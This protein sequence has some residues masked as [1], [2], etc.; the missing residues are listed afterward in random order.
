M[1]ASCQFC[2]PMSLMVHKKTS[3]LI[4]HSFINLTKTITD[5]ESA[6]MVLIK[7]VHWS[8]GNTFW[9]TFGEI[10]EGTFRRETKPFTSTTYNLS[11]PKACPEVFWCFRQDRDLLYWP[12]DL[13]IGT[14]CF[15]MF[16]GMCFSSSPIRHWSF[17]R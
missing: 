14:E 8:D 7:R 3:Y 17:S 4:F 2:F 5:H 13:Q 15:F 6:Q 11:S 16:S 10:W 9:E 12:L 1:A